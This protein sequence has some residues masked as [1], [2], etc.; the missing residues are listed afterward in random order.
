M[1]FSKAKLLTK[2]KNHQIICNLDVKQNRKYLQPLKS[3]SIAKDYV[4][5]VYI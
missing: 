3:L 2:I 1:S 4:P 5:L